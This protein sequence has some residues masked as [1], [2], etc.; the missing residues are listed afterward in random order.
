MFVKG[1][2]GREANVCR[3]GDCSGLD[4]Y[5]TTQE[6][7]KEGIKEKKEGSC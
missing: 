1:V 2:K 6:G 3:G 4:A 5:Q 7:R